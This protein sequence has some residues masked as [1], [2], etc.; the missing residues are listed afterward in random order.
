MCGHGPARVPPNFGP[1]VTNLPG[2]VI[3]DMGGTT[4]ADRG[5]VPVAFASTLAAYGIALSDAQISSVRGASKRH[6]IRELL[7]PD[8]IQESERIYLDFRRA[9]GQ[10][11]TEGGVKEIPGAGTLIRELRQRGIKVA[12]T[13]GFDHDIATL[14][15]R[16]LGWGR[17]DFDAVVC[18]DQVPRGRP[19]PDMIFVAMK[20]TMVEDLA[21]VA[22]VGDTTLDLE[23]ADRAGVQWN[24][25]VLSGAH[26]RTA[27]E[28]A[29][30][31]HIIDSVAG[32]KE[33]LG[34]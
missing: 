16:S 14:L 12:L 24:V 15:L 9:L 30:H 27:L 22:N 20:L 18:G 29:P 5:E 4:I 6:A 23:A 1:I 2:L 19:N 3:F 34:L 33:I 31:T 25:G 11:Y 21:K 32:L 10:I 13:T 28:S 26:T 17:D 7:P 8:R